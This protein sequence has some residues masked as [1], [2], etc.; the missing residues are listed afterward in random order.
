MKT[1]LT[2]FMVMWMCA[3]YAHNPLTSRVELHG[4]MEEG[5]LLDIYLTQ[6]GVHQALKSTYPDL[7]FTNMELDRYK[8]LIV[9]YL[10]GH[11]HL[12]ADDVPLVIGSGAIKLGNHQTEIKLY[13]KNYP[14]EIQKL[15]VRIDAFRENGHQQTIFWWYTPLQTSKIVLSPR[16]EFR[17]SFGDPIFSGFVPEVAAYSSYLYGIGALTLV[18]AGIVMVLIRRKTTGSLEGV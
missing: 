16:N 1:I 9:D 3:G 13:V 10:K 6:A 4:N 11:I 14:S 12:M 8:E 7:D 18:L 17:A 5:A 2:I 15:D